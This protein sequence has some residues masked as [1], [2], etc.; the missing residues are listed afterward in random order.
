M[1][2]PI[3]VNQVK[4]L[5]SVL[6]LIQ[7]YSCF[8][9]T[10]GTAMNLFIQDLPRLSVDID[11]AYLPLVA[12]AQALSEISQALELLSDEI[13]SSLPESSVTQ[14]PVAGVIRT[15]RGCGNRGC[16]KQKFTLPSWMAPYRKRLGF[17]SIERGEQTERINF[18][19]GYKVA[20]WGLA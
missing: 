13:V 7:K 9:L 2:N 15:N 20:N 12:R 17:N 11:L 19:F 4:L 8:A 1:F 5:L 10:G 14:L 16:W 6:P 3:Y 18:K